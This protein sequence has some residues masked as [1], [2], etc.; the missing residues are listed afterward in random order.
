MDFKLHSD[1]I[2]LDFW[3]ESYWDFHLPRE[4]IPTPPAQLE[5]MKEKVKILEDQLY[6]VNSYY[7]Q[8]KYL[9]TVGRIFMEN[10][11]QKWCST[12][13]AWHME[14]QFGDEGKWLKEYARFLAMER[15]RIDIKYGGVLYKYFAF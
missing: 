13:L 9:P 3:P 10:R 1:N 12:W 15:Q 4:V 6:E 7:G 14:R 2:W 5:V 8:W 11:Y